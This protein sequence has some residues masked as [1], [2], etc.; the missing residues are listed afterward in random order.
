MMASADD[1]AAARDATSERALA[2]ISACEAAVADGS[3]TIDAELLAQARVAA[4]EDVQ[5]PVERAWMS[6][7]EASAVTTA[8]YEE[9]RIPLGGILIAGCLTLFAFTTI[10]G[11]AYYA[12]QAL[13]FLVG[14]WATM[15]FR[16]IW[17]GAVFL[18]SIQQ[19]DF[20]WRLGGIANAA[21]AA[22]N[23]IAILLLSGVVFAYTKKA[24]EEG[25]GSNPA[26]FDPDKK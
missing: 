5:A 10:L 1:R 9:S 13:T 16:I 15:P 22:P 23:L 14:D 12:E 21:M 11:W 20:I 26:M 3:V 2:A 6:D 4:V 17:V 7:A 24:D 25:Q 19:V 18:G 8:V